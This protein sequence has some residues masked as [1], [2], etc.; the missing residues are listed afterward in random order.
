M[1]TLTDP[2][3]RFL[4]LYTLSP[5]WERDSAYSY[6]DRQQARMMSRAESN[7]L[8]V[9]SVAGAFCALSPNNSEKITYL[10]LDR[11]INTHIQFRWSTIGELVRNC[12]VP[13]Y[14]A[15][16]RKAFLIL[17]GGDPDILLAG[18]KTNSF[19]HNTIDPDDSRWVTIDGHMHNVW[20]GKVERMTRSGMS[21]GRYVE[22]AND[23]RTAAAI[24]KWPAP[25]FQSLLWCSWKRTNGI[26]YSP[27]MEFEFDCIGEVSHG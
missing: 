8:T 2:V 16:K 21:M 17:N 10:A 14:P 13:A 24:C 23:L 19:W 9:G 25:R 5:N 22:V 26:L 6:Y 4:D 12:K 20:R 3:R 7:F 18:V 27:Q 15:A 1:P 11:C